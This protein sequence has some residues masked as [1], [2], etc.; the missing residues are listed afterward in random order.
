MRDGDQIILK[1]VNYFNNFDL[2]SKEDSPDISDEIKE[3]YDNLEPGQK[4]PNVKFEDIK[5]YYVDGVAYL[6]EGRV[7]NETAIEEILHPF[8]DSV[9]VDNNDLFNSLLS[10][11]RANFPVLT[12][13]IEDTYGS[14][15][16]IDLI[17]AV[18][19]S[20]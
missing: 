11:A 16:F 4:R 3:Y 1:N 12:Q 14:V 17:V 2:Y 5:S 19:D 9:F 13:Q 8:V 15:S 10:E 7:D 6:I 18:A 20:L